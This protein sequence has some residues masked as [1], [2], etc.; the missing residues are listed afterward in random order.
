MSW[1]A[2][3]WAFVRDDRVMLLSLGLAAF[4]VVNTMVTVLTMIRD[5]N[6]IPPAEPKTQ[7]ITQDTEDALQLHTLTKLLEHPNFSIRDTCTKILCDR[8]VND[9]SAIAYL[10]YEQSLEDADLPVVTN[11]HWDEYYLRDTAERFCLKFLQELTSKYGAKSLVKAKFVEK[12][13]AKQKWGDTPKKRKENFKAYRK[14][15]NNRIVDIIGRVEYCR[16][17][18]LALERSGLVEMDNSRRTRELPDLL[19]EVGGEIPALPTEGHARRAREH[20]AEERRLRRQHREAMVLNDGTRPLAREDIIE[21]D[22]GS[23]D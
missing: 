12:W 6:E 4:S 1:K 20:S 19:M 5:D 8:A 10:L 18:L 11:I 16:R 15:R 2:G 7:Y 3:F 22:H 23:P 21:R 9:P 14:V 13:L 17:G